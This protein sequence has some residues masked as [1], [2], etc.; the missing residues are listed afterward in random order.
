MTMTTV[1]IVKTTSIY[2]ITV[3]FFLTTKLNICNS[4]S[5]KKITT[6]KLIGQWEL[7]KIETEKDSIVYERFYQYLTFTPSKLFFDSTMDC[8]DWKPLLKGIYELPTVKDTSKF[9]FR[10]L[11]RAKFCVQTDGKI[12]KLKR[13]KIIKTNY[14]YIAKNWSGF[15]V[16]DLTSNSLTTEVENVKYFYKWKK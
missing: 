7:Y 4:Q 11:C 13:Y 2:L 12:V 9:Y 6:E 5:L 15:E 14:P 10:L 16:I 1:K 8:S 3:V